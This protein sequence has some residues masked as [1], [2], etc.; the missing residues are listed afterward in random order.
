MDEKMVAENVEQ[1]REQVKSLTAE[2]ARL[3]ERA[4]DLRLLGVV[5]EKITQEGTAQ[6]IIK[7]VVRSVGSLPALTYCAFVFMDG[8]SCTVLADCGR[9]FNGSLSTGSFRVDADLTQ[10]LMGGTLYDP[11]GQMNTLGEAVAKVLAMPHHTQ[12]CLVPVVC[13]SNMNALLCVSSSDNENHLR[14]LQ[15]LLRRICDLM[16]SRLDTLS[17]H[18]ELSELNRMLETKVRE[19]T[20]EMEHANQLLRASEESLRES[21]ERYRMLAEAAQDSIFIV[22]LTGRI[23]YINRFG[24][25]LLRSTPEEVAG[26]DIGKF[27]P[28]QLRFRWLKDIDTVARAG[29]SLLIQ[30]RLR[31]GSREVWLDTALAPLRDKDGRITSVLAVARDITWRKQIEESKEKLESQLI[32][33]QKMEAVGRVAG[34]VAHD[35]NNLLT[36]VLGYCDLALTRLQPDD[37]LHR[38]ILEIQ[39]AA[40]R[41][42]SLTRQLLAFS[43]K[44]KLQP[45]TFDLAGNVT[46][47]KETLGRLLGEDILLDVRSRMLKAMVKAD[48]S[49]IQQVILSLAVNSR[50]AMPDGGTLTLEIERVEHGNQFVTLDQA[51]HAGSYVMLAVRDT[52]CGMDLETQAHLFEPFF[53]TKGEGKGS[54]LGLATVHGIIAQSGGHIEVQ[55]EPGM[56]TEIKIYLPEDPGAGEAVELTEARKQMAH[57]SETVLLVEDSIQVRTLIRRILKS[58]GYRVLEA[59]DGPSA[60]AM[61]EKEQGQVHLLLT[62]VVMPGMNGRVLADRLKAVRPDMKIL[63]TSGYTDDQVILHGVIDSPYAFIPKPF[64]SEDLAVK[65]R[66]V[67]ENQK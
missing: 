55:S 31:F 16:Q 6:G 20:S 54:G 45:K 22:D 21:E 17:L 27:L 23:N 9:G 11:C 56:G 48:P 63:F 4:E 8:S 49:Q 50:D 12:C 19:R 52:G 24:A 61:S 34:G 59:A 41:A 62:D 43:R 18:S 29:G 60:I 2:N 14:N 36:A 38:E 40:E 67:L 57:G 1:L 3:A 33:S 28:T 5:S 10:A 42:T 13:R 66:S 53:T 15:P 44:Q 7:T 46:D 32:Q 39:E 47:L 64:R 30:D 51:D 58:R 35:F 37:P 25:A 65:I 26:R